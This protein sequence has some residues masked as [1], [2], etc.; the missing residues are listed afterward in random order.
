ML[1]IPCRERGFAM[2]FNSI[3][4]IVVFLPVTLVGWFLLQ[5]MER[6]GWAR[7]FLV[8][9][10]LWF[11]GY[12]NIYY[13][14]ILV[15]SVLFNYLCTW[16]LGR[17]EHTALRRI[18]FICGI[19]GNLGLL[20]YFK[21]FNFFVDNCNF[22]LHT[23]WQIE[24]IALPLGISFYTFQQISYVA[25]CY[26]REVEGYTFLEYACFITFFPQ[27]I[28]GPIV[29]HGEFIPQLRARQNRKP[30]AE[31]MFDG[32][33]LFILGLAKKVLLA[34][35]LAIIVN[36]EY[37]SIPY[38]DALSAWITIVCYMLELYFDF[39]GYCDMARGIGRMLGFQLPQNFNSPLMATSVKDFWRR[40]HMT[41]SRFLT[42]YIYIPLGG[43]RRGKAIQCRN[44]FIVFLISGLWHGAN[45]TFVVWGLLH[46]LAM[47]VETLLPGLR[48][49]REWAN[50]LAT[51]LFVTFTFSIFRS[52]SLKMGWD[53]T[54]KLFAGGWTGFV[55]GL[56]NTLQLPETY[57]VRKFLEMA[58]PRLQ[59]PFYVCCLAILLAVSIRLISGRT[60]QEWLE[61]RGRTKTGLVL[62]TLLFVW[63]L[64]SLSQVSV[65]LYFDF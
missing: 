23:Q 32:L 63:S 49:K 29:L 16:L 65:F 13:L 48:F 38:L 5:Q 18:W 44:I 56:C 57:P 9:M 10:S 62:L 35:V 53:M 4:F 30:T 24:R 64:I 43:N 54:K 33:G 26:R 40:W 39:S 47:I 52:D 41:L 3:I 31:G 1:G 22:L 59:N 7:L 28:A 37:G 6:A 55:V 60:A 34:D 17:A 51:G 50:R 8:G 14:W 19:A 46:G 42:T 12:Y 61:S 27:L 21:Y 20:F 2:L 36:G 58:V 15:V 11:Y 25:D 45:W